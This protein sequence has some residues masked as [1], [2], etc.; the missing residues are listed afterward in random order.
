MGVG[1]MISFGILVLAGCAQ[2]FYE[3]PLV[4]T[5]VSTPETYDPYR[6]TIADVSTIRDGYY[7]DAKYYGLAG[8]GI[9]RDKYGFPIRNFYDSVGHFGSAKR[10]G[11]I[12]DFSTIGGSHIEDEWI[13]LTGHG[14]GNK[15]LRSH[16]SAHG[17][18]VYSDAEWEGLVGGHGELYERSLVVDDHY[19]L[20][21]HDFGSKRVREFYGSDQL[22][23]FGS[24]R[25]SS[26]K[27]TGRHE[28]TL[29]FGGFH[30]DAGLSGHGYREY[31]DVPSHD[32]GT[33]RLHNFGS[34]QSSRFG[35]KR[36]ISSK[37]TGRHEGPLV[38]KR[39]ST[40]ETYDTYKTS[41][42]DVSTIRDGYYDDA[43]YYGR[44][45]HGIYRDNNG[46]PISDFYDLGSESGRFS[47]KRLSS[48]KR[49]GRHGGPLVVKRVSTP[50]TYDTYKTSIADVSTIRDG[51]F[52]DARY[53]GRSGHGIYRDSYDRPISNFYDYGS[54]KFY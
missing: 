30:N 22:S 33:K 47:S 53:Y 13:G 46:F 26:T 5:R 45:G 39:V 15:N 18:D 49:S 35:S 23:R 14:I 11:R 44:S 36:L 38:I 16:G 25:L 17:I 42:A 34:D 27:H 37:R 50:E 51:Y 6:V 9:Y 41:I 32:F 48:S 31:L 52:D 4:V 10:G 28:G 7:D 54:S 8:H 21:S 29:V 20:P 3:K 1:I 24:K 40:P 12:A 2:A 19:D 43:R